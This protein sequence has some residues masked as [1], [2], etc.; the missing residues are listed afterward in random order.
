[1]QIVPKMINVTKTLDFVAQG[2]VTQNLTAWT[3]ATF[4]MAVTVSRF[5]DVDDGF[6]EPSLKLLLNNISYCYRIEGHVR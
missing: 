5:V 3:L 4:T 2:F 6:T 1:M